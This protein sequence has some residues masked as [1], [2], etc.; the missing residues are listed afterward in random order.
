ME[1]GHSREEAREDSDVDFSNVGP[2][3]DQLKFGVIA[4]GKERGGFKS[5]RMKLEK[6]WRE[7]TG[8]Y[9][10][11]VYIDLRAIKAEV[12]RLVGE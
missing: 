2:G 3:R 9:P 5:G 8:D 7:P 11:L 12:D 1:R 10:L 6:V 4:A